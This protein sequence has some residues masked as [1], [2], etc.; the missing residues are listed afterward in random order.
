MTTGCTGAATTYENSGGN[1]DP[2]SLCYSQAEKL[3][4]AALG[5]DNYEDLVEQHYEQCLDAIKM[6]QYKDDAKYHLDQR[7]LYDRAIDE[8]YSNNF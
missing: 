3:S 5:E 2:V 6:P 1:D 4:S 7:K 8:N